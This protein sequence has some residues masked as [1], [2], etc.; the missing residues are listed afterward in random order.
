MRERGDR[1]RAL[2]QDAKRDPARVE[3]ALE[4]WLR[5]RQPVRARWFRILNVI[6]CAAPQ[7]LGRGCSVREKFFG[8]GRFRPIPDLHPKLPML[9]SQPAFR[10]FAAAAKSRGP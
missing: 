1:K 8:G 7:P 4:P 5:V 6:D 2:G 9:R 3:P 10:T